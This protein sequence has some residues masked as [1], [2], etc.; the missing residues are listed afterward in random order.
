MVSLFGRMKSRFEIEF[1]I[2][3]VKCSLFVVY[4]AKHYLNEPDNARRKFSMC[5]AV[6]FGPNFCGESSEIKVITN[7]ET[8]NGVI[9]RVREAAFYDGRFFHVLY[10][11]RPSPD[12][13]GRIILGESAR[14]TNLRA[15]T[16]NF[17]LIL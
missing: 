13:H 6:R 8:R 10:R 17:H 3:I 4:N 14:S 12:H 2:S 7:N 11:Y 5:P 15:E 16:I 9:F 1:K